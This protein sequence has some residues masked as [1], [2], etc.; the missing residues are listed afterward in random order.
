M[1][2]LGRVTTRRQFALLARPSHRGQSGPLRVSYVTGSTEVSVA[3]ATGKTVGNAVARNLIRRRLRDLMT[4]QAST[5]P[6][7]FYLIRSGNGT[8][9]LSYDELRTHLDA[10]I[11]RAGL[12]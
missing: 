6:T 4:Q 10:A 8:G 2:P 12:R 3:F 1:A 9:K 5:L 11:H 7:G